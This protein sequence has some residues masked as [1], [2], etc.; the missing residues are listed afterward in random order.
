MT[1]LEIKPDIK[2]L[3]DQ[4][5]SLY[6]KNEGR[7][8]ASLDRCTKALHHEEVDHP[9]I[10][11]VSQTRL[12]PRHELFYD[13]EKNL[14]NN[15]AKNVLS[16][17]PETDF[18]PFL[19][20]FEGVTKIAEAFGC[21][22]IV[23]EN[24]DP[25][26]K[27]PIIQRAEDVYSVKKPSMDHP[28]FQ[29]VMDTLKVW[30]EKTGGIVPIGT[31]DPQ[32]PLNVVDLLWE[33][34]DFFVSLYTE[35]KAVH[36]L[37]KMITEVFIDFYSMQLEYI[38]NHACPVH[39]FPLVSSADGISM[40]DDEVALLSPDLYKEFGL[41]YNSRVAE[42]FNGVYYHSC[43]NYG[44][45]LEHITSI[46][47]LRGINGHLSP[48][49]FKPE[50]VKRVLEKKVGLFV[51]I[52]GTSVGWKDPKWTPEEV[53]DL[54]NEYY[55]PSVL[56]NAY[57]AGSLDTGFALVGY[58]GYFGYFHTREEDREG[59]LIVDSRGHVVEKNPLIDTTLE[60]KNAN[61][62]RIL[63]T[64]AELKDRLKN[65]EDITDNDEYRRFAE[66]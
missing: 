27:A 11:Q 6:A 33:T 26:V 22:I 15:M 41:S 37:L 42:H 5:E 60:E 10:F 19:D 24:S 44:D 8:K 28:V 3:R 66:A 64:I 17:E 39:S 9:P 46:P 38:D 21:E 50:Y 1:A 47:N 32:S 61:Y 34:N 20:P 65:G 13:K 23:P 14:I 51:G 4:Y 29:D 30:T 54:Y 12:Y 53:V 63:S 31:T 43:G 25:A 45:F 35:K 52:S 16:M 18:V 58:G 59:D 40:S 55:L 62:K 36:H 7:L 56:Q 49:E 48:K 2:T 57:D